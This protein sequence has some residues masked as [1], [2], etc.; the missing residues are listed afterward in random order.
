M[1]V[2]CPSQ[3]RPF[4]R[5]IPKIADSPLLQVIFSKLTAI[6][7]VM[8]PKNES[9]LSHLVVVF[10]QVWTSCSHPK[11]FSASH[12]HFPISN[13]YLRYLLRKSVRFLSTLFSCIISCDFFFGVRWA[14]LES[15]TPFAVCVA[16]CVNVQ[17]S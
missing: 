13:S 16:W 6:Y 2:S 11:K 15:S 17:R 9:P 7:G 5:I 10:V 14:D 1:I 8:L 4:K 12:Q 3:P